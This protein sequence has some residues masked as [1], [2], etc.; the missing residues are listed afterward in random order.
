M[1]FASSDARIPGYAHD[2]EEQRRV[3]CAALAQF[4]ELISPAAAAG[5]AS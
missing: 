5:P 2:D 1:P 4:D 3:F